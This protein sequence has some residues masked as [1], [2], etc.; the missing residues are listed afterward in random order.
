VEDVP[1]RWE[2]GDA[3]APGKVRYA[4]RAGGMHVSSW[5]CHALRRVHGKRDLPPS[6]RH[7]QRDEAV[8]PEHKP[9]NG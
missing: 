6:K 8:D 4:Y 9:G 3:S 2:D 7:L 5:I 1:A